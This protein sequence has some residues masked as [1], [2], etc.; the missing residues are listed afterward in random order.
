MSTPGISVNHAGVSALVRLRYRR[1]TG[2][3]LDSQPEERQTAIIQAAEAAARK[4]AEKATSVGQISIAIVES[5]EASVKAA[6]VPPAAPK[7]TKKQPPAAPP[8]TPVPA[9]AAK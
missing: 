3:P 7:T 8:V 2:K 9:E 5:V 6:K 4:V 1:L